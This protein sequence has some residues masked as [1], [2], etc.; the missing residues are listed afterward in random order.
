[1]GSLTSGQVGW[2]LLRDLQV[3]GSLLLFRILP[4]A[5]AFAKSSKLRELQVMSLEFIVSGSK[6]PG[7]WALAK[8]S[9]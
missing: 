5:K 9:V 2:R 7:V 8:F 4:R 6:S 1:M 3:R